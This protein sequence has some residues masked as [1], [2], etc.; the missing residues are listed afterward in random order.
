MSR[1]GHAGPGPADY[2]YHSR[3]ATLAVRLSALTLEIARLNPRPMASGPLNLVGHLLVSASLHLH[4]GPVLD[5][6]LKGLHLHHV[7]WL[8]K[9]L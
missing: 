1:N 7:D 8:V 9:V 5:Q 2:H 6:D 3:A 4:L